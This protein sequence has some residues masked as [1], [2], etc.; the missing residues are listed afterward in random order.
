MAVGGV[1]EGWGK[2]DL[3]HV[4]GGAGK[5]QVSKAT[6]KRKP[7]WCTRCSDGGKMGSKTI[8]RKNIRGDCPQSRWKRWIIGGGGK[9]KRRRTS[10]K[11]ESQGG[12]TSLKGGQHTQR[13][14]S[15]PRRSSKT[16]RGGWDRTNVQTGGGGQKAKLLTG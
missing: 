10:E 12:C 5:C 16:T 15:N 6:S 4:K 2:G 3:K 1:G 7:A 13:R 9:G 11:E 14:R 8:Q